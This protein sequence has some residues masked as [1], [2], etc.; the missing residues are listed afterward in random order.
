VVDAGGVARRLAA[1]LAHAGHDVCMRVHDAALLTTRQGRLRIRLVPPRTSPPRSRAA[2][3]NALALAPAD[4]LIMVKAWQFAD[5]GHRLVPLMGNRGQPSRR[6]LLGPSFG[7]GRALGAVC[8]R[9]IWPNGPQEIRWIGLRRHGRS[10]GGAR[11][12]RPRQRVGCDPQGRRHRR[13]GHRGHRAPAG[14]R[15]CS[16]HPYG[17][18]GAVERVLGA[19]WRTP[20]PPARQEAA[21]HE[22]ARATSMNVPHRASTAMVVEQSSMTYHLH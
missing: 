11:P 2:P 20:R 6:E 13:G 22:V 4:I 9:I 21:M 7:D 17:A 19:L 12:D 1:M 15:F 18:I 14:R 8:R 16:S 10:V 3:T 5:L